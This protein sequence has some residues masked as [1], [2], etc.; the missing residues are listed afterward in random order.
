MDIR[1]YFSKIPCEELEAD[2]ASLPGNLE[3]ESSWD[4]EDDPIM[5]IED[6]P[7]HGGPGKSSTKAAKKKAYKSKLTHR[8]Q[9]E[10][11][12]PWVYCDDVEKGMFCRLCQE[13]GKPPANA[14]GAWT[15][16]GI[17]DWNHGTDMLKLHQNSKWHNEAAIAARMAEQTSVLELQRAAAERNTSE[18]RAK[19]REVILKLLRSVYFLAKHR[20]PHTTTFQD[21]VLKQHIKE[22]PGNAQY[23]STFSVTSL[24]EATATW[25]DRK[26]VKESPFFSILAD[27]CVDISTQE[28]L[29]VC[30]RWIVN[31]QPEE[32]FLSILHV[33]ACDAAE[34][35]E[36]FISARNLDYRKLVG[37]GYDGAAVFS[38]S[39]S[40]VQV[41]MR[42]HC[43]HSL[44]I[45]CACHRLQLAS[46]QAAASVPEIQK[47]FGMMVNLW[48]LFHYS[49]KKAEMLKEILKLP[50]LKVVKP[51][52]TRWLSHERCMRAI[53]KDLP[54]LIATLQHLH[55]T[56]GD[57]EAFGLSALLSSFTGVASIMFLSE[58]LDIL[59]T[60]NASMQRKTAD[61]SRLQVFIQSTLGELKSLK[62]QNAEWCSKTEKALEI[63]PKDYSIEIGRHLSGSARTR[64][65]SIRTVEE[66]RESVVIPYLDCLIGNINRR[67]S[68]KAVK[69]L[70]ASSIFN[71]AEFLSSY[72]LDEIRVLADFYG[73]EASTEYRGVTYTSPPLLSGDELIS[74]WKV[75]RRALCKEKELLMRSLKLSK[76]PSL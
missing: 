10:T 11:K 45:H 37:Q 56:T 61:F 55:E 5:D 71:P 54:A 48:K 75:F 2:E 15:S 38:G 53:R 9:W 28:E 50:L 18:R 29:S 43:A 67:F 58:V 30:C 36:S 1:K 14:R 49:P 68:D 7:Q 17:A 52:D 76:P 27:E 33:L 72:G 12:Y 26:L 31:G 13:H 59:A 24:I 34:A 66:Y 39:T 57:A 20:I 21:Q 69:L 19:N 51:S 73:R 70:V 40:G 44:Y 41:R 4:L 65:V 6:A 62:S 3:G 16:R 64:F 74:E 46:V 63:L 8:R 23:T 47:V 22:A 25:I 60:M 32:H 42:V 35:L